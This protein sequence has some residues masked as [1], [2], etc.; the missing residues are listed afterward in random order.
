M[1]S[2]TPGLPKDLAVRP[3]PKPPKLLV[4]KLKNSDGT[5]TY[6]PI[7]R[8]YGNFIRAIDEP[9]PQLIPAR[10]ST[11]T[12]LQYEKMASLERSL[13]AK[14]RVNSKYDTKE[15]PIDLKTL[16]VER[17][18]IPVP[19]IPVNFRRAIRGHSDSTP[20]TRV[21]A[22]HV[23]SLETTR[24]GLARKTVLADADH[25]VVSL[26]KTWSSCWDDEVHAVY[27]YNKETGEATW[28]PP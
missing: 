17:P 18:T 9:Y 8:S 21:E 26:N 19:Y 2:A 12:P 1:E 23:P 15:E 4:R 16:R 22:A 28:I 5:Q 24:D 14:S 13:N 6:E 20:L 7:A 10:L 27:Y 11:R 25:P 3:P